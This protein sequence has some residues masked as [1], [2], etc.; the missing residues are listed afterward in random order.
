EIVA[1]SGKTPLTLVGGAGS[2]EF[3]KNSAPTSAI[4]FGV[5]KPAVPA[6]ATDDMVFS[7]YAQGGSW[8][9][10]MRLTNAGNLGI[11]TVPT[12]SKV[13]IAAQDGLAITG[14]GPFLTLRDTGNSNNRSFIQGIN[15]D[16][17]FIPE[18]FHQANS[19][20]MVIKNGS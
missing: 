9:E 5:A 17:V 1:T 13:E 8:S 18:S 6:V 11:G 2:M 12:T 15:G 10:R 4:A 7:T 16:L 3:W 14:F 19:S 20:A